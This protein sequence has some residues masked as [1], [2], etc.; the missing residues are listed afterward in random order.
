VTRAARAR[1]E[2]AG[3]ERSMHKGH[4]DTQPGVPLACAGAI[5]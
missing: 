3:G 4:D 2:G 1:T 5:G